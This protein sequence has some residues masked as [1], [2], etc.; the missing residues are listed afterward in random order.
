MKP[1]S[2][3]YYILQLLQTWYK[4]GFCKDLCKHRKHWEFVFMLFVDLIITLCQFSIHK[5]FNLSWI[6]DFTIDKWYIRNSLMFH[7]HFREGYFSHSYSGMYLLMTQCFHANSSR[8]GM[9]NPSIWGSSIIFTLLHSMYFRVKWSLPASP[10]RIY[11][12]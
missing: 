1:S 5:L 6:N 9:H 7:I 11:L 4:L 2:S 12:W 10:Q 8:S 3:F